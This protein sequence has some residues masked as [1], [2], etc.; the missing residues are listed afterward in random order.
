[1]TEADIKE[2]VKPLG[3]VKKIVWLLREVILCVVV[4]CM[5]SLLLFISLLGHIEKVVEGC[6]DF[7]DEL[8]CYMHLSIRCPTT[9]YQAIHRRLGGDLTTGSVKKNPHSGAIV[10]ILQPPTCARVMS[11]SPLFPPRKSYA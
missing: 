3:I 2:L 5:L 9:P 8:M 10:H 6:P 4:L 11:N 1:M 7:S